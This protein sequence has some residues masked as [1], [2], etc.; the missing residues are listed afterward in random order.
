MTDF[1][2]QLCSNTQGGKVTCHA[3]PHLTASDLRPHRSICP[4]DPLW[5]AFSFF[6]RWKWR[7]LGLIL[8]Y[9]LPLAEPQFP[10]LSSISIGLSL[11]WFAG[12]ALTCLG[13]LMTRIPTPSGQELGRLQGTH[14]HDL[15]TPHGQAREQRPVQGHTAGHRQGEA[16][17]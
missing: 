5:P 6:L 1:P 8:F 14:P 4:K 13:F 12:S 3:D 10:H 17:T 16:R 7:N 2:C 9:T 11:L 15:T